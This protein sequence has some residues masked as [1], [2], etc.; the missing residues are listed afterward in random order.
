VRCE[1]PLCTVGEAEK[2][3]STHECVCLKS[4][5]RELPLHDPN[6]DLPKYLGWQAYPRGVA[7][8][9]P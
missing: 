8:V 5:I 9:S 7:V 6:V 3:I 2:D 4:W 1:A